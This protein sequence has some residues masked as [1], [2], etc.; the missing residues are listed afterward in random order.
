MPWIPGSISEA[1]QSLATAKQVRLQCPHCHGFA[2]AEI[3]TNATAEKRGQLISAS[4]NEHRVVCT[5]ADATEG[6]VYSIEYPRA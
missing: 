4:I 2:Y 5:A 3:P 6:R 1:R